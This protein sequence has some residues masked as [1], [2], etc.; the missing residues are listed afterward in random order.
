MIFTD[1]ILIQ[2]MNSMEPLQKNH[3]VL[4]KKFTVLLAILLKV[5]DF[6][7]KLPS[8]LVKRKCDL[9]HSG[10]TTS[11]RE[12]KLWILLFTDVMRVQKNSKFF[13]L[14]HTLIMKNLMFLIKSI[15]ITCIYFFSWAAFREQSKTAGWP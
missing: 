15:Q 6:I 7:Q 14:Y 13:E 12:L 3:L 11:Q 1:C 2:I 5:P 9:H 4:L 8:Y 10:V